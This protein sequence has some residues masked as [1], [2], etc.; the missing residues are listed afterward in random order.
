[1]EGRER[2]LR[3]TGPEC[4]RWKGQEGEGSEVGASLPCLMR[5]PEPRGGSRE[6]GGR[7]R[8]GSRSRM[9]AFTPREMGS[10]ESF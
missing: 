3:V 1:M 7:V 5:S 2:A 9:S 6:N 10:N 8:T 4:C